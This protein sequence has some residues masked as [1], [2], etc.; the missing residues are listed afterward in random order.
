MSRDLG[1]RPGPA[2]GSL[3]DVDTTALRSRV[4]DR[5]A[6]GFARDVRDPAAEAPAL[7]FSCEPDPR[8]RQALLDLAMQRFESQRFGYH[9]ISDRRQ[10]FDDL[11][12]RVFAGGHRNVVVAPRGRL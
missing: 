3:P 12:N 9:V 2:A 10:L 7:R 5:L 11:A 1:P 8:D 6:T 4:L